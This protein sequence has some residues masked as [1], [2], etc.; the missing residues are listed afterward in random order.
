MP[1][2]AGYF[3]GYDGHVAVIP[4][5]SSGSSFSGQEYLGLYPFAEKSSS[6]NGKNTLKIVEQDDAS[7]WMLYTKWIATNVG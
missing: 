1:W 4:V 6:L 7:K 5:I 3:H 2:E